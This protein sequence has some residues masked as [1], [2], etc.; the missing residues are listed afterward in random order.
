MNLN[1]LEKKIRPIIFENKEYASIKNK[2]KLHL[3]LWRELENIDVINYENTSIKVET[4]DR[5]VRKIKEKNPD[6][7]PKE[8]ESLEQEEMFRDYYRP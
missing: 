6:W 7:F 4:I 5:T 2:K 1:S 8:K 3:K